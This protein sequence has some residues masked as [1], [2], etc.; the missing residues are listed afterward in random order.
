MALREGLEEATASLTGVGSQL[1]T[2]ENQAHALRNHHGNAAT[3]PGSTSPRAQNKPAIDS[4]TKPSM[5]RDPNREPEGIPE[6]IKG[7]PIKKQS[8]RREYEAAKLLAVAGYKVVQ[9]P[10]TNSHG[11][12][13]D[14]LIEGRQWDCYSPSG[15][16]LNTVRS[17]IRNKVSKNQAYSI[18]LNLSDSKLT[19]NEIEER[20]ARDPV[21]GLKEVKVIQDGQIH[22]L[23]LS[24]K[25]NQ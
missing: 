9:S 24:P 1:E 11:K 23:K 21:T 8:L 14:Y 22:D 7:S 18:I 10:P 25:G 20:L 17:A 19:S 13:P 15:N 12:N 16:S 5:P 4:S 3:S 2:L 6:A